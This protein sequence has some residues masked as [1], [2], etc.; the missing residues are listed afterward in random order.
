GLVQVLHCL[1]LRC[2][3]AVMLTAN[4]ALKQRLAPQIDTGAY[5]SQHL[6]ID[7][8]LSEERQIRAYHI[9]PPTIVLATLVECVHCP[10]AE[11]LLKHCLNIFR[12]ARS[13][14]SSTSAIEVHLLQNPSTI[15]QFK[16][17]K[18]GNRI[19]INRDLRPAMAR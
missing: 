14:P 5:G 6:A 1:A 11:L 10:S 2:A 18:T 7:I 16:A 19:G 8:A 9:R 3:I 12:Q 13:M 15:V 4:T 17:T